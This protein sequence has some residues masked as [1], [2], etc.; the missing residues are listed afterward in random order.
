MLFLF[1]VHSL[2]RFDGWQAFECALTPHLL[3][4]VFLL[5]N[6]FYILEMRTFSR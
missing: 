2:E 4:K 6:R 1:G 5:E 3:T